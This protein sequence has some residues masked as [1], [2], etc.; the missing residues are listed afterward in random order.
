M[1]NPFDNQEGRFVVLINDEGEHSLWPTFIAVPSGWSVILPE[2]DR[3][4]CLGYIRQHW[5][6]MRPASLITSLADVARP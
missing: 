3:E 6:D 2:C 1:S 5:V 4:I